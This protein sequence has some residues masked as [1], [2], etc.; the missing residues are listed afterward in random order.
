MTSRMSSGAPSETETLLPSGPDDHPSPKADGGRDTPVFIDAF[1]R[2]LVVCKV[3]MGLGLAASLGLEV[4][5][6]VM[7]FV[8]VYHRHE[9]FGHLSRFLLWEKIA[10]TAG[11]VLLVSSFLRYG[12]RL[13]H[14]HH[15]AHCICPLHGRTRQAPSIQPT[16]WSV[17]R[18]GSSQ[19][20]HRDQLYDPP[21]RLGDSLPP[22]NT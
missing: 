18:Y 16:D 1:K 3:L 2:N 14:A 12:T 19:V 8:R 4:W 21:Y 11:V 13:V 15:V 17:P 22:T 7:S 10:N 20:P 9:G 5:C 6:M